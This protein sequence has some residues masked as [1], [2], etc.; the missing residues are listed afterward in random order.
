MWKVEKER[1]MRW[2]LKRKREKRN[3]FEDGFVEG[4]DDC[5]GTAT[6][7]NCSQEMLHEA[8]HALDRCIR[9][10]MKLLRLTAHWDPGEDEDMYSPM[11]HRAVA[12]LSLKNTLERA[13]RSKKEALASECSEESSEELLYESRS[14]ESV[15]NLVLGLLEPSPL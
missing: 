6:D 8:V 12:R 2:S 9:P 14:L 3:I 10:A 11:N 7:G 4:S 5:S 1:I 15:T 13:V